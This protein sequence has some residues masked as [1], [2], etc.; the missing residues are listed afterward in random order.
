MDMNDIDIFDI[1]RF[2]IHDGEG[3]RTV[4]FLQG[5]PLRCKWCANPESQTVG[6][7][8]LFFERKCVGCGKCAD[9]CPNNAVSLFGGKAKCDRRICTVCGKCSEYCPQNAIKL[10]GRKI[11]VDELFGIV[12][13][14]LEYYWESGGGVTVSGG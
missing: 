6:R 11:S 9:I 7:K 3:I 8:I 10:S 12:C 13:R 5:C 2:A 1:E 4:V 14:D